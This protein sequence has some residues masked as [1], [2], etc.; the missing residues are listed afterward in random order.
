[1]GQNYGPNTVNDGMVMCIDAVDKNSYP[2]TGTSITDMATG[3]TNG[4]MSG[5]VFSSGSLGACWDFDGT[6]D[7]IEV[8]GMPGN[9]SEHTA[10]VWVNHDATG[11][12]AILFNTNGQG[13]YPRIMLISNV[14]RAQYNNGSTRLIS[15]ITISTG[16]WNCFVFTYNTNT[17]GKLYVDGV[18]VGND[19]N[20]GALGT[21]QGFT[22]E[23]GRD[24]NLSRFLDG[25]IANVKIYHKELTAK[26]V[27]QNY[28]ATKSRF[29][30]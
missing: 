15:G 11:N 3:T 8:T 29:G 9:S 6:D 20:T 27:L 21:S 1:M 13:I 26:Q 22:M 4:T 10:E 25:K 14:V 17:G 28:N 2:A 12:N 16:V 5:A 24:T 19:S 18:E 7:V 30:V 23:L